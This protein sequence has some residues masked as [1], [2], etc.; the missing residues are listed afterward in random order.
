MCSINPFCQMV[1]LSISSFSLCVRNLLSPLLQ[2]LTQLV[3]YISMHRPHPTGPWGETHYMGPVVQCLGSPFSC[4]ELSLKNL[5]Q[6]FK[7]VS[8]MNFSLFNRVLKGGSEFVSV[9]HYV[10]LF[11]H[12][13]CILE[14]H[15]VLYTCVHFFMWP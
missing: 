5:Q 12:C 9:G 15:M 7:L 8:N 3:A 1:S 14:P 11:E 4:K 10:R 13:V 2:F 6:F